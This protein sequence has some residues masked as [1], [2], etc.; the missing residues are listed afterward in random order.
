MNLIEYSPTLL[1]WII[2]ISYSLVTSLGILY[3]FN[4]RRINPIVWFLL[5]Q[6][7]I[8]FGSI[9]LADLS[10]ESDRYYIFLFFLAKFVYICTAIFIW[11]NTRMSKYYD[12]FWKKNVEIDHFDARINIKII[13]LLSIVITIFYYSQ[14]GYNIFLNIILGIAIDDYS[15]LR[16]ATYS[17]DEYYAAGYVNQFKNVLLPVTL[18]IICTWTWLTKRKTS[19]YLLLIFGSLFCVFA[20][21]GTG[22]RAF[23]VYSVAALIFGLF[24]L[25]DLKFRS[26][27]MPLVA[28]FTIFSLMTSLYK[29]NSIDQ[30][31][32]ILA[33]S[34]T[35]SLERFFYTE[36]ESGVKAFRYFYYE[37][38]VYMKEMM[39]QVKGIIPGQEGSSLEHYLFS[40]RHGTD[41]GTAA[42]ST[43]SGFYY[44]GGILAVISFYII[45]AIAHS[46]IFYRFLRGSRTVARIFIYSALIFYTAKFVSGGILSLVNGGVL[47]LIILLFLRR[48]NLNYSSALKLK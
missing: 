27:V 42:Y 35:K 38:K 47:T 29:V 48:I 26:L 46:Y 10:L 44:N 37:D 2:A 14:V 21:L 30:E 1:N 32:N 15:T 23:L 20:L 19:F 9:L 34:M 45:L 7:L 5:F 28:L 36:Q 22:Q 41:R 25:K 18:S 16:L 8:A 13:F 12:S 17:G 24:A 11:S 4:S 6:W 43:V 39:D 40:R 3:F 31:D 33:Q